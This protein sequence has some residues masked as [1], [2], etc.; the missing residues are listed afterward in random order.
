MDLFDGLWTNNELGYFYTVLLRLFTLLL[1]VSFCT[2]FISY[3]LI[4][5]T[6][7]A[8]KFETSFDHIKMSDIKSHNAATAKNDEELRDLNIDGVSS[9]K[10]DDVM[11]V[12]VVTTVT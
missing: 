2:V 10:E 9:I 8:T 4:H 6:L 12:P 3:I 7:L 11:E 5:V 1:I